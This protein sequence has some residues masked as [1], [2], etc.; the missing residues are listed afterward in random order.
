MICKTPG[1]KIR[2]GGK[3]RGLA[4]GRGRGPI[5]IPYKSK[6]VNNMKGMESRIATQS[7]VNAV[8]KQMKAKTQGFGRVK[9]DKYAR[10]ASS[11]IN[12]WAK[13]RKGI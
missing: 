12:V 4:R 13:A 6:G 9:A 3:G 10:E 5:G 8:A 2:S 11:R 1:M 7:E